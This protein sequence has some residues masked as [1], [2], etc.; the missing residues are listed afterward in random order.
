MAMEYFCCYHSYQNKLARLSDQEVGRLFRALMQYSAS[1]EA[2]ELAGR[3]SLAFD[4]IADD[5]NRAKENYAER[6]ETNKR[7]RSSTTVHDRQRPSTTVHETHQNENKNKNE[8]KDK[9][10]LP[11]T[12]EEARAQAGA[13]NKP[14][15][16]EVESY[17]RERRS[18]VNPARFYKYHEARSWKGITDWR[19]A[20]EAWE[21][22]GIDKPEST[23]A[24]YDI[25]RAEHKARTTVP[26]I[27]KRRD[28]SG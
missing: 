21:Q 16:Q 4:F 11:L 22:N 19:A 26:E 24:S 7:N 12:G 5:I 27:K 15:L 18:P 14:T 1:G 8:N 25:D 23:P 20:L 6:C 3:E 17:C 9:N 28:N 13:Q 2:P 10:K